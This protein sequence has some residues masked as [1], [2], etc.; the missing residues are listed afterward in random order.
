MQFEPQGSK[1]GA[2]D[3]KYGEDENSGKKVLKE[4]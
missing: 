3:K 1:G 2:E 4:I